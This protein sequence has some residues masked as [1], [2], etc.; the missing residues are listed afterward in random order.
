M[1]SAASL[2]TT[3][4]LELVKKQRKNALNLSE[5]LDLCL[6]ELFEILHKKE[7]K[8]MQMEEKTLK[9]IV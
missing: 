6:D 5:V 9:Y 1:A 4:G 3:S 2:S 7:Q 8:L